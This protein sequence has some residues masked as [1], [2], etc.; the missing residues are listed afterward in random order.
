MI[1]HS[2]SGHVFRPISLP[3]M[4]SLWNA[5]QGDPRVVV[6]VLDGVV[7]TA[8]PALRGAR[9]TRVPTLV[10]DAPHPESP[11]CSHGTH[12]TS[13]LFGRSVAGVSGIA[14]GC[15]GLLIPIFPNHGRG[16]VPQYDVARGIEQAIDLG[17]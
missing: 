17:A 9:L 6:A 14:P 3:G 7:D 16:P 12:V 5:T 11:M 1:H 13:V 8:H 10:N 2:Y 15:G 4:A